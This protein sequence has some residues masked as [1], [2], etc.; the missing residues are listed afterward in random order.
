MHVCYMTTMQLL[1]F[2]IIK[3]NGVQKEWVLCKR[4]S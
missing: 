1:G 2:D 4:Y 3:I